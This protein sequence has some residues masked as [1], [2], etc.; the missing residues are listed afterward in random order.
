MLVREYLEFAGRVRGMSGAEVE[1]RLPTVIEVTH[2]GEVTSQ[3]IGTLSHGYRQRV[4]VAQAIMHQPKLLI[5]DEPTRGLD[6]VQIVE[7]RNMIRDLKD[8]HTVLISSHILTEISETCDRILVLGAGEIIASGT[9]KS[10][11]ENIE[12]AAGTTWRVQVAI[13]ANGGGDPYRDPGL[14]SIMTGLAGVTEVAD[15]G[16][17]G[18]AACFDVTAERDIR[19]ELCRALVEAGHGVV[20]LGGSERKLENIFLKLVQGGDRARN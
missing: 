6:P 12:P 11:L 19:A 13:V 3:V 7:M 1:K 2:L 4:G 15:A 14:R 18:D 17:E 5:L 8:A 9:E 10:L 16:K 20:R